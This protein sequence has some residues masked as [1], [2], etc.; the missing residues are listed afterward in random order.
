LEDK[1]GRVAL[2]RIIEDY[3]KLAENEFWHEFLAWVREEAQSSLEELAK[4]SYLEQKLHFFQ[5]KHKALKFVADQEKDGLTD[6]ILKEIR[7]KID[8]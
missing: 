5:G 6:R 3:K 7:R 1:R 8:G 2:Q 4:E